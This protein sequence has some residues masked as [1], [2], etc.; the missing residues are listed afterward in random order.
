MFESWLEQEKT[1]MKAGYRRARIV[2]IVA[3]LLVGPYLLFA[4]ISALTVVFGRS[5]AAVLA[6][7]MVSLFLI[8]I[9]LSRSDYKRQFLKPL[10]ALIQQEFPTEEAREE[11]AGQMLTEAVQISCRPQ[12]RTKY[13]YGI[14]L[15]AK[16][17]CY[18]RMPKVCI[19]K[20][21]EIRRAELFQEDYAAG[22]IGRL[23]VSLIYG[24]ALY[25]AENEQE[26]VW[27]GYFANE[28]ELYQAFAHFRPLLSQKTVIQ[29][30]VA[31]GEIR[32]G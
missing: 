25:T 13:K 17:Y 27:K 19:I 7:V 26:P 6:A 29:D 4:L 11:F 14:I 32:I 8:F 5:E 2:Y 20:N 15:V 23:H 10:M 12:P 22:S 1:S 28:G 9:L 21:S 18:V 3:A 16:N 31:A 30:E 24:L